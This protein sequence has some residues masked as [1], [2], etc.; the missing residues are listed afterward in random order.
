M[1]TFTRETLSGSTDGRGIKVVATASPGT[2]V[3][4]GPSVATTFHEVWLYASNPDIADH[5]VTVEWGGTSNPDDRIV[6]LVPAYS[7]LRLL[8]PGT[9][10]KGN[11][12][13]L[14]IK[15][16]ADIANKVTVHGYVNALTA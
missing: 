8:A 12:T 16:F 14:V 9:P 3:H 10:L 2:T 13:P 7:G 1:T 6:L 15:A 5:V 4:T 11:A